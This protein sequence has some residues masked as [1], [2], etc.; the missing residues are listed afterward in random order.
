MKMKEIQCSD[1]MKKMKV[2]PENSII[3]KVKGKRDN[4]M[5]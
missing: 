5:A 4:L 2:T 3:I 1:I